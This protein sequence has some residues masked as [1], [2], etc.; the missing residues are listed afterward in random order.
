VVIGS[1]FG[2]LRSVCYCDHG[3]ILLT[4][5]RSL[6]LKKIRTIP[7]KKN[8]PAC[9]QST[10]SPFSDKFGM[11]GG[12]FFVV[13]FPAH[14]ASRPT[15]FAFPLYASA[16]QKAESAAPLP[17][18]AVGGNLA[19]ITHDRIA[20]QRQAAGICAAFSLSGSGSSLGATTTTR[21]LSTS[22]PPA[23]FIWGRIVKGAA[24]AITRINKH[25]QAREK[26]ARMPATALPGPLALSAE[27]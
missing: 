22:Q 9:L 24:G 21:A 11:R 5:C 13:T 7:I 26:C 8:S 1:S 18:P 17:H 15:N 20:K 25:T 23:F 3:R 16:G 4:D 27:G 14:Q 6:Y 2:K 10:G 19:C 12:G